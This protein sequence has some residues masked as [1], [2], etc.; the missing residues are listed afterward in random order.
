ME[1]SNKQMLLN[2]N[3]KWI[4]FWWRVFISSS[5][6]FPFL[7]VV[8]IPIF[9]LQSLNNIKKKKSQVETWLV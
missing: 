7:M 3:E 9:N 8:P 1:S 6:A 2:K 5:P 4:R